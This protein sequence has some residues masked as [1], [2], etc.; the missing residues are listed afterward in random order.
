MPLFKRLL[1]YALLLTL[2]G[3]M[4]GTAALGVAYW[5]LAPRLPSVAIL[6]D[7]EMQVPMRVVSADGKLIATFGETRRIP[8]TIRQVPAHVKDAFLAAEDADFY[9][10]PGVDI[11]GTLRAALHVLISGGEKVQGGSTITQQVARNFFLSPEK[12]YTRKLME[13]FLAFRIEHELTK[14]EILDLYLNKIFLGHRAYGVAAAAE[15]YYGKTL[16]QLSIAQCAMLA[17]LPKFPSTGNPVTNRPKAVERRNYVLGRMLEVGFISKAQYEH[18]VHEPDDAFPHEPPVQVE[19]PYV[20]EMARL[21]AI[22]QLGNRALTDGYVVKTT[23]VSSV[24]ND[25]NNAVRSE[26]LAYDHRHG[27]RGPEAHV[28]LPPGSGP[29]AR[30]RALAALYPVAGL[31]PGIVSESD[32]AR[33]HVFLADG[34]TV[35]LDLAAVA[36]ARPYINDSRMGL[37]P[38][39]VDQVLKRGDVVRVALDA[40]GHWQLAQLPKA[41]AALVTLRPDDGAIEA[42]VGGFSY[43]QSKFNRATQIARQPGSSFKPFL[44][45][46][47]FQRGFTPA[48]IINDAPLVFADP[49]AKNGEWTPANDDDKFEGPMRLREA[50]AQS[51]NLVTIRL[52]DAIGVPY[53]RQY[54]TRFGFRPDAIPDNLSLSLG[55]A[56]VSP[57]EMARGYAVFANGGFLVNPYFV[58]EIDDRDGKPVYIANPPRACRDCPQRLLADAQAGGARTPTTVASAPTAPALSNALSQPAPLQGPVPLRLAPRV[59]GPR[60]DYLIASLMQSVIRHGTGAAAM[61]LGRSDLSGKTGST[62]DF[63]DGWFSGFNTDIVT[64]VWVG[65]DDYGSLGHGEFGARTALP[66][67]MQVMGDALQGRPSAPLPMP[68]GIITA[69]INR[70]TGL[71]AAADDPLAMPEIFRVEDYDRLKAQSPITPKQD[72]KA[73]DVF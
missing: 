73:Y 71:P 24:Q 63:R 40:D 57:M 32:A 59:I 23:I 11:W 12:S 18:A 10:H 27:W 56:S 42:L 69:L 21:A 31:V 6:K 65:F 5:I 64:T 13:W 37:A 7:V 46:A 55:T 26:L 25:A 53:A 16:D 15:Y 14:D 35:D 49:S 17:S 22:A 30:S 52:V 34:Q 38:K 54:V 2:L 70:E 43:T 29:Q 36:W 51:K 62:N 44:Y 20:A 50:L 45:S 60:N 9:H 28:E 68:P 67:W 19:A 4:L 1:R 58:S 3:A 61:A 66:I 41:Q 47:A 48:S 8:V 72:K 39:R 33:A